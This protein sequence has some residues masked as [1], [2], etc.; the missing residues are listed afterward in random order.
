MKKIRVGVLGLGTVGQGVAKVLLQNAQEITRRSGREIEI[1]HVCSGNQEMYSQLGLTCQLSTDPFAVVNDNDVDIIVELFGGEEPARELLLRAI[2]NGKPVVTANKALI[3]G[4]GNEIFAA[5]QQHDVAVGYEAAVAGGIP[6]IKTIREGLVANR[7]EWLAGIINGTTNFI[8]TEMEEKGAEFSAVLKQAQALGYAEAD[9][10]FDVEGV[11]AAH[12]LTIL[13]SIAFG[14]PL[15]FTH[16]QIE[17]I[18]NITPADIAYADEFGYRFKHL[19]IAKR[20]AQG[21]ELRVHPTLI[22]KKRLIANVK[23][24]MNAIVVKGDAVGPTLH[25]GAGAGSLATASSVVADIV[26]VARGLGS[27]STRRVPYLAFQTKA[28]SDLPIVPSTDVQSAYYLRL[29][30]KDESGV[31]AKITKALADQD[32]SIEAFLQKEPA[33]AGE[34]VDIVLLTNVVAQ[35]QVANAVVELE[36][37][38]SVT[39]NVASFHLETFSD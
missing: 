8:L 15:Q 34:N 24:V 29:R 12:K 4:F 21:I 20:T 11:D 27:D 17:G 7:I 14:I 35:Q 26:D 33:T 1:T 25:Y 37:L 10:T 19:G 38:N 23:G 36:S 16:V 9:P 18:T 6:I 22:P 3:A 5:A 28:L 13:A 39:E 31:L 2:K 32:I 30:A